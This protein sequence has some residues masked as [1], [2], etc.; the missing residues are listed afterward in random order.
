MLLIKGPSAVQRCKGCRQERPAQVEAHVFA[1]LGA[2]R[3]QAEFPFCFFFVVFF[4]RSRVS[5]ISCCIEIPLNFS[6][7]QQHSDITSPTTSGQGS[8]KGIVHPK[9]EK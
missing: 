6:F 9:I 3:T 2:K 1:R 4:R 8:F 7:I 5:P